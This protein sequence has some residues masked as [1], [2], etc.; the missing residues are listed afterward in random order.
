MPWKTRPLRLL[1]SSA[2]KL[3]MGL[4][5]RHCKQVGGLFILLPSFWSCTLCSSRAL[6]PHPPGTCMTHAVHHQPP[7]SKTD[8]IQ[9]H[10]SP[11]FICLFFPT[12]GTNLHT[13]K[14]HSSLQVFKTAVHHHL[15]SRPIR[16]HDFFSAPVKPP[17]FPKL[18]AHADKHTRQQWV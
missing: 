9:N 15:K 1:E 5:L 3:S 17:P 18:C 13:L 11:P 8:K 10:S 2:I 7:P 12:S 4:S 6:L 14:S 16:N